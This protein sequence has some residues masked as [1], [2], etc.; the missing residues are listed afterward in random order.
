MKIMQSKLI[1]ISRLKRTIETGESP[2][3]IDPADVDNV[4]GSVLLGS[5]EDSKA[6]DSECISQICRK[7][8][9]MLWHDLCPDALDEQHAD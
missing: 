3:G 4:L 2:Q 1:N 9:K 8:L 7:M 5:M 6:D